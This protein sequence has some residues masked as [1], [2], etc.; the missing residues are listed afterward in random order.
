[1]YR[2]RIIPVLLIDANGHAVK[3]IRFRRKIDLGDPVNAVSIFNAFRVDE[4]VLLDISATA[5]GR[6]VSM[7]LLS[8]IAAEA[9]MPF[10]VGGGVSTLADIRQ[11]LAKGAEKVVIGT[12]ALENP[13]FLRAAA[14]Q[15]GSSSIIACVDVQ[16]DL[17]GRLGV[18]T[19]N[20]TAKLGKTP[21]EAALLMEQMGAGEIIIQSVDRD[22][23]MD[24]YDLECLEA[25]AKAVSVPVIALG[26][27]GSL[28]HMKEAYAR[29]YASAFASGSMFCFQDKDRGVLIN[30]PGK[31]DLRSFHGIR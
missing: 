21:V 29:T 24:G 17:F 2:P 25:V 20:A 18:R 1:M 23:M 15:F 14:D 7:D 31:Q 5:Q 27:A 4:L 22:G 6:L 12:A 10:S 16:R 8:D 11:I 30:Y 9:R 26:G 28:T 19:R 3:T 13:S